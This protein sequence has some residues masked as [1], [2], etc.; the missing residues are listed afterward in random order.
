MF[1]FGS[2][3]ICAAMFFG[4]AAGAATITGM[5]YVSGPSVNLVGFD[6][7]KFTGGGVALVPISPQWTAMSYDVDSGYM[8]YVSGPT[9]NRV[10]FNGM[11]FVGGGVILDTISPQWTGM[12]LAY[13]PDDPAPVPLPASLP[14]AAGGIALFGFIA[15]RRQSIKGGKP[16]AA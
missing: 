3:V 11:S 1:R 7:E 13:A 14:L 5:Y 16:T 4:S 6:G 15:G 9:L 12:S 10:E 2:A 8:Y